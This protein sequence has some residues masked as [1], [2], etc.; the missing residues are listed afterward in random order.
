MNRKQ[1]RPND[2]EELITLPSGDRV[3]L[4]MLEEDLSGDCFK[5][6]DKVLIDKLPTLT[7]SI[8]GANSRFFQEYKR[9]R[10][11]EMNRLAQMDKDALA[12]E[13]VRK[14]EENRD[15]RKRKLEAE[16]AKKRERRSRR[17]SGKPKEE[18]GLPAEVITQIKESE[19][20]D[21]VEYSIAEKKPNP[22]N[23]SSGIKFTIVEEE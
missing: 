20:K 11:I 18:L 6:S 3:P 4:R 17:K 1:Q 23:I 14:F 2:D 10:E 8:A 5:K 22:L 16:A 21:Q 13:E 12:E 7:G 15:A 9:H 19:K